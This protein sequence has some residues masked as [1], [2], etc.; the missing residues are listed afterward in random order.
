ML[1]RLDQPGAV[2]FI[3]GEFNT[4]PFMS[5]LLFRWAGA[6]LLALGLATGAAFAADGYKLGMQTWTL[7]NL[8]FEQ[9][10]EFCVKHKIK[11][12][13]L[14]PNHVNPAAP[15]EELE[16][17]KALL[18]KNGLV[19]YTFGV[20]RTTLDKE[21]N[22]KLFEFCKY[23]GMKMLVVEPDDFKILDNLEALAK[24]YDIKVAIHNHGIKSM[25]GNPAVVR[26]VL[27]HR[28]PRMGVCLDA[29]WAASARFDVAKV[30]EEYGGRVFDIHLKDKKVECTDHGDESRDTFLGEGDAKLG[31]LL[32]ALRKANW[33]G[34][35]AIETDNN[36]KDPA[37]HTAKAVRFVAENSH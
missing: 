3:G 14:I 6:A 35:I 11:Y 21:E 1:W 37:E 27:K 33:D 7:R 31:S 26:N 20:A 28:D 15:R 19:P 30:F 24:E 8:D 29:G 22:R 9:S 16:K 34:V 10:V 17:K 5:R 12:L 36:L 32:A 25:Y 4:N 2:R 23:F 18:E 13:Q